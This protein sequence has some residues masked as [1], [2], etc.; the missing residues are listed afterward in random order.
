[1]YFSYVP[2]GN[3]PFPDKDIY[4]FGQLTDYNLRDSAKM[5][6]NAEKGIY[7]TSLFLKQGY[8]DYCYVTIDRNDPKRQASFEFT[9]GNYWESENE[10]MILVYFRPIGGRADELIGLGRV[11]SY[12][13]RQGI[14]RGQSY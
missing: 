14:I 3:V 10:Y 2:K 4:L 5:K 8:Y 13:G 6:F 1:V 12:T 11:N 7:E 9:E